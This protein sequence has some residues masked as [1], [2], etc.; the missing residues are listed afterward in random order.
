MTS[1]TPEQC[2]VCGDPYAEREQ[3]D[4]SATLDC[5][6]HSRICIQ[7]F[8]TKFDVYRHDKIPLELE[9]GTRL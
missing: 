8:G 5:P 3:C 4:S 7:R 6:T 1:E 2:P 9:D